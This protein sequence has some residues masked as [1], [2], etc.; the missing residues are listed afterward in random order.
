MYLTENE[1]KVLLG[2][3][4]RLTNSQMKEKYGIHMF[5]NDPRVTSLAKK[6][7]VFH[8]T[9]GSIKSNIMKKVDFSKIE[10]VP[11][12]E[13]PYFQYVNMHLADY[14]D[15]NKKDVNKL[16]KYFKTVPD[17]DLFY[18]HRLYRIEDGLGTELY[19]K[20]LKTGKM[21]LLRMTGD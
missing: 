21:M 1:Y 15:I 9:D 18:T 8:C 5:T 16:I 2:I 3:R 17:N 13:M 7:G 12:E 10:V 4:N 19:I 20:D 14:I 6:Y 11:K